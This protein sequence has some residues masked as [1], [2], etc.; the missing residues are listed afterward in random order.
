MLVDR[1][2]S[3]CEPENP[4]HTLNIMTYELGSLVRALIYYKITG[5]TGEDE[6]TLSAYVAD[7]R[8]GLA[9]L[10]TQCRVLAEQM[11][12]K[13]ITLENDGL[14]RFQERMKE[15]EQRRNKAVCNESVE[16]V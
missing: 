15:I 14:E 11:G 13:W 12:W 4:Y 6:R 10:I 2:P 8:I 1:M 7:A 9:D 3:E 16:E 5:K